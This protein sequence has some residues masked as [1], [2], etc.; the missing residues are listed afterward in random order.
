VAGMRMLLRFFCNLLFNL[1]LNLEL[2]NVQN[3]LKLKLKKLKQT[4]PN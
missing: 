3:F 2:V 1:N 4:D